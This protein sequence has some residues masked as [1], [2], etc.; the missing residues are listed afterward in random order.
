MHVVGVLRGRH[1]GWVRVG[2]RDVLSW[3]A[4][5]ITLLV[6]LSGAPRATTEAVDR[7]ASGGGD[8]CE[9]EGAPTISGDG[10]FVAFATAR[11]GLVPDDRNDAIDVFVRD[12]LA[13]TTE[14]VSVTS[15]GA[16]AQ[17]RS[18]DPAMSPD[19][20]FVVFRSDAPLTGGGAAVEHCFI[21]DRAA[22]TT[23]RV[24]VSTRAVGANHDCASPS[25]S[26]DGRFVAFSSEATN[27]VDGDTN[28]AEDVFLRDVLERTTIRVSVGTSGV[29]ANGPSRSPAISADGRSVAFV[30]AAS[31]LVDGDTNGVEDVFVRDL[32][33]GVTER[34][35]IAT[36][37]AQGS[38]TPRMVGRGSDLLF[39]HSRPAISGDGRYVAFASPLA[40]LAANDVAPL[41]GGRAVYVRDRRSRT[42]EL[43]SISDRDAPAAYDAIHPAISADGRSV[44]FVS[45]AP[46]VAE[47]DNDLPDV[48]VRDR[49]RG[50][51][52]RA[53]VAGDESGISSFGAP[54]GI[55]LSADGRH[56][57]FVSGDSVFVRG[58]I[59]APPA[60]P[61][62]AAV[63]ALL[64]IAAVIFVH[65]GRYPVGQERRAQLV[66]AGAA[67]VL[68]VATLATAYGDV[69]AGRPASIG[70]ATVA[71][72]G[73]AA[74]GA[75]AL[76]RPI[77]W[78]LMLAWALLQVP[79]IAFDE[80]GPGLTGQAV[81]LLLALRHREVG[82]SGSVY[83]AVGVN[84]IGI[85]LLVWVA[86]RRAGA[87]AAENAGG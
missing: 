80:S 60:I 5:A 43:V 29:Q 38:T 42:T 26:A 86:A 79:A 37:G 40:G 39:G 46:L 31:N 6:P 48:F 61:P 57:A 68:S 9:P 66:L 81:Q 82:P 34:V 10:R 72:I 58:P 78:T 84:V 70:G 67:V 7:P 55:A 54:V 23:E 52:V 76:R 73:I 45:V 49:E 25:V 64:L 36:S 2:V 28:R 27:L 12:R 20:R 11:S 22:R 62:L 18:R 17:A 13:H 4:L 14:R 65:V 44:A 75:I 85:A 71:A 35:T 21:R 56:V 16:E 50:T 15:T 32:A 30:S 8:C 1:L 77:G 87:T 3:S 74:A 19:G 24:S 53:S 83:W 63:G 69:T 59:E 47:D 41:D 51:T 33:A